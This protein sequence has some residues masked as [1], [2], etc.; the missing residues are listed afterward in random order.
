[1]NPIEEDHRGDLMH[2]KGRISAKFSINGCFYS[3]NGTISEE[4]PDFDQKV[5]L[6]YNDGKNLKGRGAIRG[7][8]N[9]KH[10]SIHFPNKVVIRADGLITVHGDFKITGK[11]SWLEI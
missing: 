9:A 2:R 8:I 5:K 11:G 10:F 1:M 4:L 3:F 7:E 6:S